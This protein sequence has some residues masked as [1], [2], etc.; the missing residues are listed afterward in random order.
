MVIVGFSNLGTGQLATTAIPILMA[1]L[2]LT[3]LIWRSNRIE[4]PIL[5]LKLFKN[6]SFTG[7]IIVF[8]CIQL[9]SLGNAFLLPNFIQLVNHNTAFLAGLIVL[10]AGV[11]GAIMGPIGGRLL[12]NYG[13]R[14]PVLFGVSL[15]L[16]E[17][18]F[19]AVLPNQ[20]NNIFILIVYIIYMA[21]M[22]MILGD[23]MTDTLAV[24]DESETTQGNAIL[25]TA[26]QFA[27]A[28]GTS[29][30]SAIVAS[31][32]KGTK[33]ADLTRIGTQH[34]Y[35]FLLCLVILIM[36]LFIKY[37]GRRTATK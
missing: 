35:I 12:D 30:T 36:A 27:G 37:V 32:Q 29:I 3:L 24:I 33:S 5:D 22:G 26:Q 13:A 15:M 6:H 31:S 19:F 2:V 14:K 16:L 20:M 4:A 7:H 1:L 8:F 9:I 28:V 11:T 17:T 10:P 18:L 21:G 25:N 34:A 23:V